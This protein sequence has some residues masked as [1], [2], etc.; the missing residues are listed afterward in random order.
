MAE[1]LCSCRGAEL[2]ATA[3]FW[4][5]SGAIVHPFTWHSSV[6]RVLGARHPVTAVVQSGGETMCVLALGACRL[7][8]ERDPKPVNR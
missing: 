3:V 8:V 6:E 5:S 7:S 2:G 4:K 1:V